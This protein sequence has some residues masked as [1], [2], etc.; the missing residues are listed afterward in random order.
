MNCGVV[1]F[2]LQMA[3]HPEH[4]DVYRIDPDSVAVVYGGFNK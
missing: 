4:G 1:A 3:H 2:T